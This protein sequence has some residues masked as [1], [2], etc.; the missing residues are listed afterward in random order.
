MLQQTTVA[1]VR[2]RFPAFLDRFPTL[3]DL[4]NASLDQV[5]QA[6]SGLGYYRRAHQLHAAAQQLWREHQG[7]WP[8]SVV[9]LQKLAGLGP[10]TAAAIA[11]IAFEQPVLAVDTNVARVLARLLCLDKSPPALH[12][13]AAQAGSFLLAN[14]RC[15]DLVQAMMELGSLICRA[16]Q[17]DCSNCPLTGHCQAY[18]QNLVAA[19]PRIAA[20]IAKPTRHMLGWWLKNPD[21]QSFWQRRPDHGLLAGLWSLPL[22][23]LPNPPNAA[24]PIHLPTEAVPFPTRPYQ[25]IAMIR[26]SFTHFHL[27]LHL[28]QQQ[29]DDT[30]LPAFMVTTQP[31]Q[32]LSLD[33]VHDLALSSLMR[34]VVQ[35]MAQAEKHF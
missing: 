1:T 11:A 20:R 24:Q 7:V 34:K 28:Y 31:H 18:Q 15:G 19:Y 3:Q 14:D 22:Q 29:V 26:H 5:L 32:W 30:A 21:G 9:E 27:Q 13:Q 25:P 12:Q 4:A 10:Y 8:Q 35:R 17:P 16:R 33:T 2:H 6:W 23:E